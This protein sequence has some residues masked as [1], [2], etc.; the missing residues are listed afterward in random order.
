[1]VYFAVND[2]T[3]NSTD[4]WYQ[5]K[6]EIACYFNRHFISSFYHYISYSYLSVDNLHPNREICGY[7]TCDYRRVKLPSINFK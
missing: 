3:L 7:N 1:M 2:F 4:T 5:A 6:E